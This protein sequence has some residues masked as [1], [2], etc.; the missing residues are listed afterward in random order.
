[1]LLQWLHA[2]PEKAIAVVSHWVF[3]RHLFSLFPAPELIA[4]F[5]NAE[6]RVT[7]LLPEQASEARDEL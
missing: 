7:T 2:R 1:M 5:G 6:M 4:E 3:L